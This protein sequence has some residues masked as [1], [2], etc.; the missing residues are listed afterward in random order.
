MWFPRIGCPKNFSIPQAS[1][2][3][4][5]FCASSWVRRL[6]NVSRACREWVT[7]MSHPTTSRIAAR[8]LL[9]SD[10]I[11]KAGGAGCGPRN[12][13]LALR[14]RLHEHTL[15]RDSLRI[16]L[17]FVEQFAVVEPE[18][19]HKRARVVLYTGVHPSLLD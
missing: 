13:S 10:T 6:G 11:W 4:Y 3:T 16:I 19:R 1:V 2:C 17:S 9:H 5:T 18:R 7:C 8:K 14:V 15:G 12:T